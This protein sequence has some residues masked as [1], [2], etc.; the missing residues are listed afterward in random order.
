MREAI[1]RK[2]LPR[3][4]GYKDLNQSPRSPQL[5]FGGFKST[6]I[7]QLSPSRRSGSAVATPG[8]G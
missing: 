7:I 3:R 4:W 6:F 2:G 5:T 1:W 8:A